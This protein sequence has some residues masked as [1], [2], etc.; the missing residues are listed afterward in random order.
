LP[1]L[2]ELVYR[3]ESRDSLVISYSPSTTGGEAVC[4]L[5]VYPHR[6]DLCLAGGAKLAKSD[7]LHLLQGAGKQM[8]Q[9]ALQSMADF[10]RPEIETLI[11]AALDLA[12]VQL[13]TGAQGETVLKIEAQQ[14]RA[15]SRQRRSKT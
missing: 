4:A 15:R 3:Y 6:I 10:H 11:A 7:P 13:D 14:Q 9:V 1:G 8:R 12:K 2:F 5:A